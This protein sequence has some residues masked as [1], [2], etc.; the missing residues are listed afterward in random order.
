[1]SAVISVMVDCDDFFNFV[2]PKPKMAKN[3]ITSYSVGYFEITDL[4]LEV[5]PQIRQNCPEF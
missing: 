1:M 2:A 5:L 3:S 4:L